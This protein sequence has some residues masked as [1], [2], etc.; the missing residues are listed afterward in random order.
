MRGTL[1]LLAACGSPAPTEAPPTPIVLEG[2][3]VATEGLAG[4]VETGASMLVSATATD[5]DGV[6]ALE[7][8]VRREGE[9]AFTLVPMEP[10]DDRWEAAIPTDVVGAPGVEYWIRAYDASDW[11][12]PSAWPDAGAADPARVSV[13]PVARTAPYE[14]GFAGTTSY[15]WG[16][17]ELGWSSATLG[18]RGERWRIG[19]DGFAVHPAGYAGVPAFDGWLVSPTIDLVG[20]EA[21]EVRW[22]ERGGAG[23]PA[24]HSLWAST[25]SPDPADGDF[26][27]VAE[28]A[29][30][31]DRWTWAPVADLAAF[32]G[33]RVTL[34]WR[35][36][37]T[38]T[39]AWSID[40]V[41]VGGYGPDVRVVGVEQPQ[42]DPGATDVLR[43]TLENPGA[44]SGP[45]TLDGAA[46][47]GWVGF[48]TPVPLGSL[49]NGARV[50]VDLPFAV[51]AQQPDNHVVQTDL[52][53]DDG[54]Q[55]T[56]W[57]YGLLVGHPT[58]GRVRLSTDARGTVDIRVGSG[59]PRMPH[60]EEPVL[61]GILEAGEHALTVDLGEHVDLLP[62][63]PGRLRWFVRVRSQ[64]AGRFLRFGIDFDGSLVES[65]AGGRI[66]A[67]QEAIFWLPDRP[68]PALTGLELDPDPLIPGQPG[69]VRLGLQNLGGATSG[70]LVAWPR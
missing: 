57:P 59:D 69:H 6:D 22:R 52:L 40:D 66:E 38:V 37:G 63:T 3:S 5:P 30:P 24:R 33:K 21:P 44:P 32:G 23:T 12:V 41:R 20:I 27:E 61:Q 7:L 58:T 34:A 56:R 15:A 54:D 64:A 35:Y 36:E 62:S 10:V 51:A 39:A 4:P 28:L 29:P 16:L 47:D 49:G 48:N 19:G 50:V 9:L 67:G 14:E 43:V 55:V 26:V 17:Y 53:L 42:V 2:P 70:A 13:L 68:D 25:G 45:V 8:H 65:A 11:R 31:E 46:L 60:A 18:F 1:V